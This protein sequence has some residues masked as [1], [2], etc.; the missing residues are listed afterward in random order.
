MRFNSSLSFTED[1]SWN[2]HVL[3]GTRVEWEEVILELM[4][5]WKAKYCDDRKKSRTLVPKVITHF[6]IF[7]PTV[8]IDSYSNFYV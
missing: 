1:P 8:I 6:S 7:Y 3:I 4:G 5:K 2:R